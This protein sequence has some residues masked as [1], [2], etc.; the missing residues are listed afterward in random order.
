MLVLPRPADL[1][2]VAQ[3]MSGDAQNAAA[4]AANHAVPDLPERTWTEG[5]PCGLR[6]K[7][8]IAV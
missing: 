7:R 3:A 4:A 5:L 8:V 2:A 1:R 6:I